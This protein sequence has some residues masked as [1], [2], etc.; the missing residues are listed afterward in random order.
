MMHDTEFDA[1][2]DAP[3]RIAADEPR[4]GW[5]ALDAARELAF[6]G[7]IVFTAEPT[8]RVYVDNG[9]AYFAERAG[10]PSLGRQLLDAGIADASQ[11]EK[12]TVRV[13]DVEHLGRLFDRE[14]SVD[15]DAVMVLTEALTDARLTD[16]AN[17]IVS[18]TT[19]TAYRH[20]ES[21][22]HR[23]F[24]APA[25][26]SRTTRPVGDVAQVD[27]SVVE[28]LPGLPAAE[29]GSIGDELRIEWTEPMIAE[30][31]PGSDSDSEDAP[32][33][34]G[35]DELAGCFEVPEA[36][37]VPASDDADEAAAWDTAENSAIDAAHEAFADDA[38]PREAVSD[39]S[40]AAPL[41]PPTVS[42]PVGFDPPDV[43]EGDVVEPVVFD[44]VEE[45]AVVEPLVDDPFVE[46]DPEPDTG[47]FHIRW[48]DGSEEQVPVADVDESVDAFAG[49]L[50]GWAGPA[51]DLAPSDQALRADDIA[52]PAV[53]PIEPASMTD[54]DV[55]ADELPE[56]IQL[57]LVPDHTAWAAE[58]PA[59]TAEESAAAAEEPAATA[60]EPAAV[61]EEPA[62]V[63]V[64]PAAPV[65]EPAA[66]VELDIPALVLSEVPSPDE[67]VPDE[68]SN[69]VMRA[70][71][72][73][74]SASTSPATVAPIA[75]P[76][77]P[78]HEP[79]PA[80]MGF[81]PPTL[82]TSAEAIYARQAAEMD[83][84]AAAATGDDPAPSDPDQPRVASVVFVDDATG[85]EPEPA[86]SRAGALRRL[87]DSIR[88]R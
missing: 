43:A 30:E 81:A 14:P 18:S 86:E 44:G 7:E 11:L 8:V 36:D 80:P 57:A 19:A 47:A 66:D 38:G 17:M 73:I 64:E 83:A 32:L 60:V 58:E 1:A 71:R 12:G 35:D 40:L 63:A 87:I 26:G 75:E 5:A 68:V 84:S 13:G 42:L 85:D 23:W 39:A 52:L 29:I 20:H 72:A 67:E 53:V 65:E 16:L 41:A 46:P 31:E 78:A 74:E 22:V 15:R 59:A 3:S 33:V 34:I 9:V 37:V 82:E 69:A 2:S 6:T 70:I 56:A 28:D 4:P 24:V 49:Q 77:A 55:A 79:E 27:N 50:D 54:V 10:D 48:P 45:P 51:E 76:D 88:R 21:G 25:T 61:A 62:A